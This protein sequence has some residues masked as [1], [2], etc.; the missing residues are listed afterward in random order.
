[1]PA[2]QFYFQFPDNNAVKKITMFIIQQNGWA[3]KRYLVNH[4][5]Y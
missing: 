4:F 1:M 2:Y 3:K 5:S